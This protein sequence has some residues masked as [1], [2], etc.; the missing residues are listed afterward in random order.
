MRKYVD[1]AMRKLFLSLFLF[2]VI[3]SISKGQS[4][5]TVPTMVPKRITQKPPEPLPDGKSLL[6]DDSIPSPPIKDSLSYGINFGLEVSNIIGA[7]NHNSF[8]DA[9]F[10]ASSKKGY[11]M[12]FYLDVPIVHTLFFHPELNYSEKGYNA[13]T[14]S[15]RFR[16]TFEFIELPLELKYY[17]GKRL[18]F[19]GG[20]E[21]AYLAVTNEYIYANSSN[22]NQFSPYLRQDSKLRKIQTGPV[23]GFGIKLT[24]RLS[25]S[26]NYG[27]DLLSNY[28]FIGE[29]APK[30]RN[31]YI[32]FRIQY[33]L[34]KRLPKSK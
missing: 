24:N 14:T 23:F 21:V 30:F 19:T 15:G 18:F 8:G 3:F 27:F 33:K 2:L 16:R 28:T 31:S 29:D 9:I 4:K 6:D 5:D 17:A 1:P 11:S 26:T 7:Y 25:F 34:K 32:N 20:W 10:S 13:V 12:G 22:V